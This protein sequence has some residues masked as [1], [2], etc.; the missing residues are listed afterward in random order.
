MYQKFVSVADTA[1]AYI[2]NSV[3]HLNSKTSHHICCKTLVPHH[4]PLLSLSHHTY[5]NIVSDSFSLHVCQIQLIGVNE[6][7]F[8]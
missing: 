5:F 4:K 6:H 1:L 7:I 2:P 3:S 8:S